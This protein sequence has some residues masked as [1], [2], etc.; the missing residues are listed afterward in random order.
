MGSRAQPWP[1]ILRKFLKIPLTVGQRENIIPVSL[2]GGQGW[3][4]RDYGWHMAEKRTKWL[5]GDFKAGPAT[6]KERL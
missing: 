3:K 4:N 2:S 6:T 1:Q 5:T